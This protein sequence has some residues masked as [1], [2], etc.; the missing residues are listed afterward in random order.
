MSS[1]QPVNTSQALGV[2]P[3]PQISCADPGGLPAC[4]KAP[5]SLISRVVQMRN[6]FLVGFLCV[7]LYKVCDC[8]VCFCYA[9][10]GF[11]FL[12]FSVQACGGSS[13]L[14]RCAGYSTGP[15]PCLF[16]CS[17]RLHPQMCPGGQ[18]WPQVSYCVGTEGPLYCSES[19]N[20]K[21]LWPHGA[22]QA[23][24]WIFFV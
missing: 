18:A 16:Q 17:L 6:T 22:G 12:S 11:V 15:S 14:P 9:S 1:P 7:L 23:V 4:R 8:G 13:L 10:F 20:P 19:S 24:L 21:P 2:Q 3:S 5:A